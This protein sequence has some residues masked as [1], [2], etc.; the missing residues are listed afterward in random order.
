ME[1]S[2]QKKREDDY[3]KKVTSTIEPTDEN[4]EAKKDQRE[5]ISNFDTHRE[6][7][8]NQTRRSERDSEITEKEGDHMNK[9]QLDETPDLENFEMTEEDE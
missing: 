5:N 4:L 7:L 3:T 9:K 6:M 8:G 1:F 2:T